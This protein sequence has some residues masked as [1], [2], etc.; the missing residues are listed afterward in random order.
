MSS[1]TL[2]GYQGDCLKVLD[3]DLRQATAPGPRLLS[4]CRGERWPSPRGR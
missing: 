4:P 2:E 1:F 3:E